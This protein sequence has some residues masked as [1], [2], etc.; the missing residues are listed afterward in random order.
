MCNPNEP[1]LI[2]SGKMIKSSKDKSNISFD[3]FQLYGPILYNLN[4]IPE[5]IRPAG[6]IDVEKVENFF[7]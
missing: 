4:F 6:R 3:F 7:I 2:W 1:Y 5:L